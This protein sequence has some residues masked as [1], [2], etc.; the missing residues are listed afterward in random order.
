MQDTTFRL[1][2][3]TDVDAHEMLDS[4][5]GLPLLRGYRGRAVADEGAVVDVLLRTSALLEMCP[6]IHELDINPLRVLQHGVCA[7]DVRIR[8]GRQLVTVPTR[9]VAY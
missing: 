7:V 9:R 8:V 1:H 2:P 4:L 5:K 6:E 3:I